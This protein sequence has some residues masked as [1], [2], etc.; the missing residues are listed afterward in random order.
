[1]YIQP[2]KDPRHIH[3][4]IL[5]FPFSHSHFSFSHFSFSHSHFP[6]SH[7]PISHFLSYA[8]VC[9]NFEFSRVQ[10]RQNIK[11]QNLNIFFNLKIS[12]ASL[13][14]A[15]VKKSMSIESMITRLKA[16]VLLMSRQCPSSCPKSQTASSTQPRDESLVPDRGTFQRGDAHMAIRTTD[17]EALRSKC[18]FQ[19]LIEPIARGE[20]SHTGKENRL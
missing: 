15:I 19:I 17:V 1:V 3:F 18:N 10:L 14:V 20:T 5:I 16:R 11:R 2:C 4:L 8:F 9:T 12:L 13:A 6:I 7:F